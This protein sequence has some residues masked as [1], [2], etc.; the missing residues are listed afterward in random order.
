MT[1]FLEQ[2]PSTAETAPGN[3]TGRGVTFSCVLYVGHDG[4]HTNFNA[5]PFGLHILWWS[6]DEETT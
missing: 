4:P 1:K 2:C 6:D 5:G 3:F